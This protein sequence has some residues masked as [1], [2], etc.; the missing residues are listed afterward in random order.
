MTVKVG[1]IGLGIMGKP[2]A[3]NVVKGGFDTTVYDYAPEPVKELVKLG[4][5][6]ASS[7]Q[8]VARASDVV[9]IMVRDDAQVE[10]VVLGKGRVL[11]ELQSGSAIIVMSTI[12]PPMF[13]KLAQEAEKK[14]VG[15]LDAPVSGSQKVAEGGLTIF[16]G[17][18][19]KLFKQH[20]PILQ[21]MG[22]NIYHMG[23]DV[24][25]GALAKLVNN[26]VCIATGWLTAE[27]L[28]MA[29]KAGLSL[30]KLKKA[31]MATNSSANSWTL[32]NWDAIIN[33]KKAYQP[34]AGSMALAAKD[35]NLFLDAAKK[36][37]HDAPIMSLVA[38]YTDLSKL[39]W[40][41]SEGWV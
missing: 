19:E 7:S 38:Q 1:F 8:E 15:F 16:I 12:S 17:G 40:P 23:D 27:G 33:M 25:S 30:E 20:L 39:K 14:G 6:P 10:D 18:D 9:I 22:E 26:A 21:T 2:M 5:K 11:Q 36:V 4:A 32:Q 24:G 31:L 29:V 28:G 3:A 37:E 13:Q 34:G 41:G 35:I